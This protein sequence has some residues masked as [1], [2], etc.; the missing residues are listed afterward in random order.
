MSLLKLFIFE[1]VQLAQVSEVVEGAELVTLVEVAKFSQNWL[2]IFQICFKLRKTEIFNIK[3]L[4]ML[5][6]GGKDINYNG[7]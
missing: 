5:K 7:N 4:K 2:F 3:G 1:V 6:K